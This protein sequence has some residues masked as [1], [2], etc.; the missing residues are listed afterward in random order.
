M[1][2]LEQRLKH[3]ARL[4]GFELVGI[5]PANPADDFAHLTD[6]LARGFAGQMHYMEKWAEARR[7]PASV[8]PDVRSVIMVAMNYGD[9]ASRNQIDSGQSAREGVSNIPQGRVARYA[10]G[11]DY[12]HVLRRQLRQLLSW[13]ESELPGCR[14][15]GVVDTAPLLERDFA[16]RAGL[17]WIGKNTMLINP[18]L[19]SYFFLAAL[20]LNVEL[21]ADDP[22]TADYCGTCTACLTA[23]P[24]G[25]FVGP[26]QLDARRCLSYLT[27]ELRGDVP[28]ELRPSM[29]HWIFGCD[30]C[31]EVC[32]WNRKAPRSTEKSLE[33]RPELVALDPI[34]LLYLSEEEFR[35]RFRGTALLRTKRAGLLRNAALFLGNR[36]DRSALAAL[37]RALKDNEPTVREAA[38]WA[39]AQITPRQATF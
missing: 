22:F 21:K 5:A 13:A 8:L 12:H 9:G 30:V 11:E 29:D 36:G 19:G 39:L 31:Q 35:K 7:H 17:G 33:A 26:S 4:L 20:L 27:I 15:R 16:R 38:A 32:P 1:E 18:K 34:A 25:A 24:T 10:R 2:S 37:T 3:Q 14:G 28:H 6:W 23:C